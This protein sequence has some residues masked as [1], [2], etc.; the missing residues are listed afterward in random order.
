[1]QL[2]VISNPEDFN[3][4]AAVI[5]SLFRAGMFC[6]HLRKPGSSAG[7]LCALLDGIDPAFYPRIAL[8]QHHGLAGT[9]GITR[10]HYTEEGRK[11]AS[12]DVLE[13]KIQQGYLL[14]TSV[15]E[16][17]HLSSPG[18]FEYVFFGPV[19]NSISKPGYRSVVKPGFRIKP[20]PGRPLVIALGGIEAG[21]LPAVKE[22]GFD[23]A[24]VL[25]TIWQQPEKAIEIFTLL[26]ANMPV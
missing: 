17:Q 25:G 14:S 22:M 10:L 11:R 20:A 13:S 8:H 12:E 1:M 2:I 24:A 9:Y 15:H 4:E 23:G 16:I 5:N 6:F 26:Q 3:G 7:Q 19:F 18:P 21:H